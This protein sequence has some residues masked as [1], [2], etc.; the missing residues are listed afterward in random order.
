MNFS[1]KIFDHHDQIV[2]K[3]K[4]IYCLNRAELTAVEEK[5]I[6]YLSYYYIIFNK[7]KN[8]LITN[9]F[10]KIN[11]HWTCNTFFNFYFFHPTEGAKLIPMA[12]KPSAIL[13]KNETFK[14]LFLA[15]DSEESY[16]G[17]TETPKFFKDWYKYI[18]F[19]C[20]HKKQ[21][22]IFSFA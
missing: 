21:Q 22:N 9:V 16:T 11:L 3:E 1:Y 17:I 14:L 2:A 13:Y 12:H 5:I 8:L 6:D 19:Y 18:L 4:N 15:I 20:F 10:I 7:S